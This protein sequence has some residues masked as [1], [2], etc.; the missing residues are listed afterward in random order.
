MKYI[1]VE[2]IHVTSLTKFMDISIHGWP[3][4]TDIKDLPHSDV[5][6]KMSSTNSTMQ[7]L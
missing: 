7:L 3:P 5:K 6:R 1:C 2:K 4:I